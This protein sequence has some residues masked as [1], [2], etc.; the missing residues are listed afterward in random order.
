MES[1]NEYAGK[2][3]ST[4][5][6]WRMLHLN[7]GSI[8]DLGQET[9]L[10]AFNHFPDPAKRGNTFGFWCTD[11]GCDVQ[12]NPGSTEMSGVTD[13]YVHWI[14]NRYIATFDLGNGTKVSAVFSFSSRIAYPAN[15]TMEGCTLV[16][17][18]KDVSEMP[19][20]D[21][22]ITAL[23]AINKYKLGFIFYSGFFT[24]SDYNYGET[25]LYPKSPARTG[26]VFNGW[27]KAIIAMPARDTNITALWTPN[28]YTVSFVV[29]GWRSHR[30]E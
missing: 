27:D 24:S 8:N 16:G 5:S 15:V 13:L 25:V 1:L 18:D 10:A 11:E 17:W 26:Y 7:G 22:T 30:E 12:Y 6:R 21:V 4:W 19:A 3:G 29:N 14:P 23:W 2:K 9:P 20:E 28:Q